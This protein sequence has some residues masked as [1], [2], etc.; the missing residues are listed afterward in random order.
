MKFRT[1][2]APIAICF[3]CY[4]CFP[5]ILFAQDES[6]YRIGVSASVVESIEMVTQRDMQFGPV[7]PGQE[8]IV[9]NPLTDSQ[10]GKMIALGNPNARIKVSFVRERTLTSANGNQSLTFFYEI[11]GNDEDDQSSAELLQTDNRDLDLNSDGEYYFWIGGQ[12][13]IENAQPGKYNGDFTIEVEY[14]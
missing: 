9:I 8:Q 6:G 3:I 4:M 7:Q 12:V 13:N 14:I 2:Y 11:A 5:G 1:I 10:T